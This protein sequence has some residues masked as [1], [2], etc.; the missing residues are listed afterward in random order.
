M[1]VIGLT[2]FILD[3]ALREVQRRLLYW[4]PQGKALLR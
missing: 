4:I 3:V 1:T 2:G